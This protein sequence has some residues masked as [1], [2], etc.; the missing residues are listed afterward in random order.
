MVVGTIPC[1]MEWVD[2]DNGEGKIVE[3]EQAGQEHMNEKDSAIEIR[4]YQR[5]RFGK[6]GGATSRDDR[7]GS[8]SRRRTTI[9]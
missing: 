7:E 6:Q 4:V 5:R 8:R 3:Q 9:Q 2:E 1:P